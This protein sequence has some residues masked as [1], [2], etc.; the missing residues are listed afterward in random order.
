MR[1]WL[2]DAQHWREIPCTIFDDQRIPIVAVNY[3][4]MATV[5]NGVRIRIQALAEG[6]LPEEPQPPSHVTLKSNVLQVENTVKEK[7]KRIPAAVNARDTMFDMVGTVTST[8]PL[9][10]QI[11]GQNVVIDE[12]PTERHQFIQPQS[13]TIAVL[14]A[15]DNVMMRAEMADWSTII[16]IHRIYVATNGGPSL[17]PWETGRE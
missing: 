12:K 3:L 16:K 1:I 7:F 8:A 15:G 11:A 14:S 5:S 17:L 9:T 4:P 6:Q 10:V 13:G 2:N